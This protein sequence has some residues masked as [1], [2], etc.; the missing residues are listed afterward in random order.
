MCSVCVRG[1]TTRS[2][3]TVQRG[4]NS[5]PFRSDSMWV[6][7]LS[8]LRGLRSRLV[9]RPNRLPADLVLLRVERERS[10]A[11]VTTR[12]VSPRVRRRQRERA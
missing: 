5:F 2:D 6:T 1:V 10:R 12:R 7:T 11:A 9:S 3:S 4:Q 8:R